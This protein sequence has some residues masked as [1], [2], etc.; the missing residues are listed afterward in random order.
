MDHSALKSALPAASAAAA[1][2]GNDI[3]DK[4]C[5]ANRL[6]QNLSRW[7]SPSSEEAGILHLVWGLT[8]IHRCSYEESSMAFPTR[9]SQVYGTFLLFRPGLA[10]AYTLPSA[11]VAPCMPPVFTRAVPTSLKLFRGSCDQVHTFTFA[12][13]ASTEVLTFNPARSTS[14][15]PEPMVQRNITVVLHMR[16]KSFIHS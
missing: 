11:L 9:P 7:S 4:T 2:L 15:G 3:R 8:N 12:F 13:V 14:H 10:R 16:T 5:L 6:T 1:P